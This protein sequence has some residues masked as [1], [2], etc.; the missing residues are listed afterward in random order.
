MRPLKFGEN[1][2]KGTLESLI[3]LAIQME[4]HLIMGALLYLCFRPYFLPIQ[5]LIQ[6][7]DFVGKDPER[8]GRR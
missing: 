6:I 3:E 1:L 4:G 7:V 5:L 8:F 2:R